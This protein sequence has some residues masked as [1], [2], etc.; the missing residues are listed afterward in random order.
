MRDLVVTARYVIAEAA[1]STWTWAILPVA[2]GVASILFG[3]RVDPGEP[4]TRWQAIVAGTEATSLILALWAC[5]GTLSA[6]VHSGRTDLLGSAGISPSRL[7]WG[8]GITWSAF[9]VLATWLGGTVLAAIHAGGSL[10]PRSVLLAVALAPADPLVVLCLGLLLGTL[11]PRRTNVLAVVVL[12]LAPTL[13]DR[14]AVA[15]GLGWQ[16]GVLLGRIVS[17]AAHLHAAPTGDGV[18]FYSTAPRDLLLAFVVA[19]TSLFLSGLLFGR[20][21]LRERLR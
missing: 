12:L 8:T 20:A 5:A 17:P 15:A 14:A 9:L 18:I 6:E 16:P 3:L 1:R 2:L 4:A 7:A 13:L 21:R 10:P 19:G 11:L